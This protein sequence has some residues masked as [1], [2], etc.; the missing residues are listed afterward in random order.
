[1]PC[2][3]WPGHSTVQITISNYEA[4]Q[5]CFD[6]Q[7]ALPV[8][9]IS[10]IHNPW[11]ITT[12]PNS[13]IPLFWEPPPVQK[14]DILW[15]HM[16]CDRPKSRA[17]ENLTESIR[18][19]LKASNVTSVVL[20][21]SKQ[22]DLVCVEYFSFSQ[23]FRSFEPFSMQQYP[24][25]LRRHRHSCLTNRAASLLLKWYLWIRLTAMAP[26]ISWAEWFNRQHFP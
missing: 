1:M 3:V 23:L 10:T 21:G 25:P 16:I 8:L 9:V 22:Q 24:Y 20:T 15:C 6:S 19:Q 18:D 2:R 17:E 4:Y 5:H 26:R 12:S 14:S 13:A 11:H 7:P